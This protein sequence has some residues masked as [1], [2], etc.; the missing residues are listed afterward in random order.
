MLKKSMREFGDLSGIIRNVKTGNLIGGHQRIKNLDPS[1]PIVKIHHTDKVGTVALGYIDTPEGRWQYRE[2]D[3]PEKKEAAANVAANQ[4]GGEF[5]MPLLREIIIEL[6]DGAFDTELFGFNSHEIELMMTAVHQD[7]PKKEKLTMADISEDNPKLAKFIEQREKSRARGKDKN[8]L[9]FWV[10]LIFQS[11]DQKAEFIKSL[12]EGMEI[13]Y[14][15]YVD[16][17][18]LADTLHLAITINM[19]KPFTSKLEEGLAKKVLE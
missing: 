18:A 3:W 8:E 11:Y 13:K 14:G 2:V 9:N 16:G 7:E 5:D 10:C 4:H 15:K 6:D 19:Q 12:P 17:E 1:W